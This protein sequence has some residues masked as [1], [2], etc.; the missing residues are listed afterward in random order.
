M[1]ALLRSGDPRHPGEPRRDGVCSGPGPDPRSGDTDRM[2][3]STPE[4]VASA[5]KRATSSASERAPASASE[6]TPRG[7]V[8]SPP[9]AR[10]SRRRS[11]P[12]STRSPLTPTTPDGR[13]HSGSRGAAGTPARRSTPRVDWGCFRIDHVPTPRPC[14]TLMSGSTDPCIKRSG[15]VAPDPGD[16][17]LER[18]RTSSHERVDRVRRS[19][20]W[21]DCP[22]TRTGRVESPTGVPTDDGTATR[23][24]GS[25][26]ERVL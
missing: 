14:R 10:S 23:A 26:G 7:G 20:H 15:F 18:V 8:E 12:R 9:T 25:A 1:D 21:S 4:W 5:S 13:T 24:N 19:S 17:P 16:G 6:R 3:S 11:A 22:G 2:A